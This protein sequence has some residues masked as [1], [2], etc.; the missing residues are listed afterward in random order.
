MQGEVIGIV[1]H[2]VSRSGGSEGIGFAVTSNAAK[3]ILLASP[4]IWTGVSVVP[5]SGE[6][7]RLLNLPQP[8]GCW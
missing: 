1:R 8:A 6:L 4:P 2:I 7:P 3:E 5:L